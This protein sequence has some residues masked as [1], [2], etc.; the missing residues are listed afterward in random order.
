MWIFSSARRYNKTVG[1]NIVNE[2]MISQGGTLVFPDYG[3]IELPEKYRNGAVVALV[4]KE[5]L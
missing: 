2:I 3:D 4:F 5:G 1:L